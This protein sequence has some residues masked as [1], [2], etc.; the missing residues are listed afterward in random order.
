VTERIQWIWKF[1]RPYDDHRLVARLFLRALG[2]VYFC[3]FASLFLQVRGLA[4][5]HGILPIAGF[6]E[7]VQGQLGGFWKIYE[8]P[9]LCWINSSDTSLLVQCGLGTLL[10][11]FLIAGLFP[12]FVLSA[13]WVLWLSLTVACRDFLGFQ[14][15]NLLLESG[16]LAIFLAPAA[17]TLQRAPA[18]SGA[19]LWL[20]RWLMFRLMFLSGM[21]KLL[22]G[23]PSWRNF[24]AL[25]YH[26]ETQPLPTVFGWYT[27]HLPSS[28]LVIQTGLMYAAELLIPFLIFA[29]RRARLGAT[30]AFAT[31]QIGI[32][33][34]GNYCYFN[35]LTI[36]LCLPLFDDALIRRLYP[37]RA[38]STDPVP[39]A[40]AIFTSER[41]R[42][43]VTLTFASFVF[44]ISFGETLIGLQLINRPGLIAPLIQAVQPFR[45]I[46]NYG[47]F[48]V[49]TKT[50]PEIIIEGSNDG[51]DWR[52]YEF[53]YKPGD[54]K[55][56][57]RFVAPHQ[58]RLDWQ[59]WFAALSNYEQNPWFVNFCVR[60]LQGE[61]AVLGLLAK[62]PFQEKP[63]KNIRALVYNYEFTSPELRRKT[64]E[65][66]KRELVG[67]YFGPISLK[68]G[69]EE[70]SKR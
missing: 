17:S 42:H 55:Q 66:W 54:L 59:M 69:D 34:T 49:M 44:I 25:F 36:V 4:G 20:L 70:N 24:T 67:N 28:V 7:A 63:P 52:A 39:P 56:R 32:A 16:L 46:N 8:V 1:V 30:I 37:S 26:Y 65:W 40:G 22:S 33:I 15:E 51:Q 68:N 10:S 9:T 47:L 53:R 57:P 13:L 60:L 2:F 27:Y 11:L 35:L 18:P 38:S 5:S 14:W 45:S 41:I 31:L 58:P 50:R 48:A 23:D 19:I 12:F 64:G 61:P 21:V 6:L 62:D 43:I 29:G 3:A